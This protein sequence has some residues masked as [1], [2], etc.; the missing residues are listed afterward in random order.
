MNKKLYI[1]NI[2]NRYA[3]VV[4]ILVG[5]IF[6]LIKYIDNIFF[7]DL[8]VAIGTGLFSACFVNIAIMLWYKEKE[9]EDGIE[10]LATE[11]IDLTKLYQNK[12][13][14][15]QHSH[16]ILSIAVSGALDDILNDRRF[17]DRILR[18]RLK[19]R[20]LFLN[21]RS[22]YVEQR[23]IEDQLR[24]I[25]VCKDLEES[26]NKAKRI[27]EKLR[28]RYDSLKR[29]NLLVASNEGSLEIR[30][31][32][33]CPYFTFFR[34]DDEIIWGIYTSEKRGVNSAAFRLRV[35]NN[36]LSSQ[37]V[38]HFNILWE[39]SKSACIVQYLEQNTPKIYDDFA[40]DVQKAINKMLCR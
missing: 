1:K 28:A 15:A 20:L 5:I 9:K 37:L 7:P 22:F 12:R 3:N 38:G 13:S 36:A 17:I 26:I 21:P 2:N 10:L 25:D 39:R 23:A 8:F 31:Y 27:G 18:D 30:L 6:I 24:I 11:R 16:D 40:N 35:G 32:D 19:V 29:K 14:G 4:G 33:G 34:V